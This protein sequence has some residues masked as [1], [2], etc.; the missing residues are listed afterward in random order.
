MSGSTRLERWGWRVI[1]ERD[2][3]SR[4]QAHHLIFWRLL[5]RSGRLD[6]DGAM[7]QAAM[8]AEPYAAR[9]DACECW[10]GG[11]R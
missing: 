11:S 4:L 5:A 7:A 2:D 6:D 9:H 1:L 3:W 8:H 10:I